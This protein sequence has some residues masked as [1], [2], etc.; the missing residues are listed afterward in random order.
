MN[1]ATDTTDTYG[2]IIEI[3]ID[4][5]FEPADYDERPADLD[6]VATYGF[7]A[8]RLEADGSVTVVRYVD[9]DD[10]IDLVNSSRNYVINGDISFPTSARGLGWFAS[11]V[12][13]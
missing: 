2:E 11:V 1:T 12:A 10:R 4:A 3:V 7:D 8:Y 5:G 13:A 6:W 9:S